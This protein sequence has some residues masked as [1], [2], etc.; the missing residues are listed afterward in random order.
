M[1]LELKLYLL[2]KIIVLEMIGSVLLILLGCFLFVSMQFSMQV[3][4]T[5]EDERL[6]ILTSAI[7]LPVE[8]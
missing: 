4:F 8:A 7:L 3:C 5:V 1:N 2:I 6:E